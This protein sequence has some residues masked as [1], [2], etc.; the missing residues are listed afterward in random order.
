MTE[1]EYGAVEFFVTLCRSH[2]VLIPHME[3]L[4]HLQRIGVGS[5][6]TLPAVRLQ[7]ETGK[8]SAYLPSRHFARSR[9]LSL[10][11]SLSLPFSVS[12]SLSLSF[13][14]SL[15]RSLAFPL[16]LLLSFSLSLSLFL[17]LSLYHSF[18]L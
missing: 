5:K 8:V 6:V 10:S 13:S 7:F 2:S 16:F 9:A 11:L 4:S 18:L 15:S 1:A 3:P 12:L 17:F 14:L